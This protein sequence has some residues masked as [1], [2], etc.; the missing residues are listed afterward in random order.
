MILDSIKNAE[1]YFSV[2]PRLERAFEY[3]RSTNLAELTVGRH[4]IDGDEIYVNIMERELK[5]P[6][7]A[8]LEVHN[9]Y[10]DI[11]ILITGSEE[12]FGY[13]ERANL[14]QPLGEFD[15]DKDVQLF[16]DAHQTI[17]YMRPGQFTIL[18]PED[19]HAPMIGSGVIKKAIFKVKL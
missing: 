15:T 2:S 11:Q 8:K 4:D 7:D 1:L 10:A 14:T 18:L 9:V 5:Q 12:G 13:L 16:D 6:A 17:Y 19:A 3:I